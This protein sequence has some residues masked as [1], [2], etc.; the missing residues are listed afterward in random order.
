MFESPASH[1]ATWPWSNICSRLLPF[2]FGPDSV[3]GTITCASVSVLVRKLIPVATA[4]LV[5][6]AWVAYGCGITL[7]PSSAT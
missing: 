5:M 3:A 1:M 6:V 7:P 4:G 2:A